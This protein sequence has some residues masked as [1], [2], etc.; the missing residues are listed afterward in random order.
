M[1]FGREYLRPLI[2]KSKRAKA[3]EASGAAPASPPVT[4]SPASPPSQ[5]AGKAAYY[6]KENRGH[7]STPVSVPNQA[8]DSHKIPWPSLNSIDIDENIH[9]G[10]SLSPDSAT[11]SDTNGDAKGSPY[12]SET[13]PP[14]L[15]RESSVNYTEEQRQEMDYIEQTYGPGAWETVLRQSEY[16]RQLRNTARQMASKERDTMPLSGQS[17]L[18]LS[19]TH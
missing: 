7:A 3:D 1:D 6:L 12:E 15:S 13:L 2:P 10:S 18:Q 16:K 14:A 8:Q 17:Q 9:H 5:Q 19:N 4:E 11:G